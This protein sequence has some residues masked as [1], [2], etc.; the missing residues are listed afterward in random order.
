MAG[1]RHDGDP[2]Q[3]VTDPLRQL[4]IGCG[5]RRVKILGGGDWSNLV[6]LDLNPYHNPDV[7]AD[8]NDPLPFGDDAFSE[9]HAY[10]VLEHL[11]EQGDAVT[12]FAHFSELWRVLRPGGRLCATCP[13]PG[14][15][16]VW[17]D[18]SHRRYIG[19]ESLVFLSQAQYERQVGHT[20]MSDFR[21]IYTADFEPVWAEVRGD[22]FGF[23]LRAVKS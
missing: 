17:G 13:A 18:P 6:T 8:L 10:E 11:G 7:V 1:P 20:A 4:L 2:L 22:T 14:S 15:P 19:P 16:W 12:F 21:H 9:V 3:G 23:I 5:S